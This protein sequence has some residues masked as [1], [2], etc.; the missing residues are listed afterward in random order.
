MPEDVSLVCEESP[1]LD[2]W[3]QLIDPCSKEGYLLDA[4]SIVPEKLIDTDQI[5]VWYKLDRSYLTPYVN[6]KMNLETNRGYDSLEDTIN[7][8][9]LESMINHY[10]G[11]KIYD[12]V[13]MGY[14]FVI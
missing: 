3:D 6:V 9:Y 13:Y 14:G 4:K 5:E 8:L 7:F 10:I 11:T 12:A 2:S 1:L